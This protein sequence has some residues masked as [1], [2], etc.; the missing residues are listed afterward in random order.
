MHYAAPALPNCVMSHPLELLVIVTEGWEG[1]L[2][3]ARPTLEL[4][5]TEDPSR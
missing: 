4:H 3:A 2:A 1:R 5:I